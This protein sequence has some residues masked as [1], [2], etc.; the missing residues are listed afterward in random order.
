MSSPNQ[1]PSLPVLLA[2]IASLPRHQVGPFLILGLP[3][4]ASKDD[5]EAGWARKVIQAR[6][7][8]TATPLEDINWSRE[9]LNDSSR[10]HLADASTLNIDTSDGTLRRL[11]AATSGRNGCRPIDV[12]KDFADYR[13]DVAIPSTEE[14]RQTI[15]LPEI[16]QEVPAAG[17]FLETVRREAI[18]PWE[19][20]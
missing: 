11:D 2:E 14:L 20:K 16:P 3:K 10:R 4:D 8:L 12:E 18:D 5:I 9:V 7:N 15:A 6:R 1:P 13:P 17:L 19:I